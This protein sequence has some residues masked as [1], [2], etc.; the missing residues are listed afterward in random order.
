M[1]V[2]IETSGLMKVYR[3]GSIEV[4]ALRGVNMSVGS[5]EIVSIMGPS[6]CGKTTLLNLL[7]GL[8]KPTAGF[9][10]IDG[11][12]I[13]LSEEKTLENYRLKGVGNIFQFFNL[14]PSITAAENIELP[15]VMAGVKKDEREKRTSELLEKVGLRERANQKPEELSGGEQ[16]RV[17]IA[18]ALANDP[19]LLLA[20]EPTG[21]LD[22]E[23]AKK[24]ISLL[25]NLTKDAGKTAIMV[26]HDPIIARSADRILRLEDGLV[27]GEYAPAQLADFAPKADISYVEEVQARIDALEK[28]AAA[29]ETDFKA[30]KL[31]SDVFLEKSNSVRETLKLL[32][33][34]IK[35]HGL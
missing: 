4:A 17:A 13:T 35:R 24:V 27:T 10:T 1:G 8:D 21:E 31:T 29:L 18:C 7:G 20:D 33:D 6:G 2:K 15:M 16:Q 34:E 23:T 30:G 32:K 28:E 26:T 5:G 14:I 3:T 22:R 9:V 25:V 19:P 11:R 12:N